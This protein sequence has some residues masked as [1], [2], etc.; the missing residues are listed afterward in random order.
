MSMLNFKYGKFSGLFNP[1]GSNKLAL[2]EGTVYIT[3]D[4]KA[5]YVDLHNG[6][7]VERIRLSQIVNIPTEDEWLEY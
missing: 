3:T 7:A 1:D 5:M 4:E 2:N 6:T